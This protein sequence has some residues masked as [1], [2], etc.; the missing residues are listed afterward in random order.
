DEKAEV[1]AKCD[2]LSRLKFSP[3]LPL[4]FTEH[5][6]IMAASILNS[7]RAVETSVYVVRAFVRLREALTE[8]RDI[9]M[10]LDSL[11]RKYDAQFRVV[12]DAI[13]ALMEPPKPP[14]RPIGF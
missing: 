13:R 4:A 10:R 5:G 3:V 8:H 12:F 14:R 2:N 9:A 1:I 7:K 6:A 11:E